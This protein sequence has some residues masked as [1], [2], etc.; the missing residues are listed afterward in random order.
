M[1]FFHRIRFV[2]PQIDIRLD[3]LAQHA[4]LLDSR[5]SIHIAGHEHDA[6]VLFRLEIVR[7]FGGKSRL[8]ATLQTGHQNHSRIAFEV[9]FLRLTA[10]QRCQFVMRDLDHQL[11][12]TDG[13]DD[14]L[15]DCFFLHAVGK[16][17]CGLVVHIRLQQCF[18]DVFDGFR[19]IDLGDTSLTF[20]DLKTPF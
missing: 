14:V 18:A 9:Q 11:P 15:S 20:E 4:Q 8:T 19:N 13:I 12:R 7:Q 3:L 17:L 16:L 2:K 1:G 10:H 5:R 6:F